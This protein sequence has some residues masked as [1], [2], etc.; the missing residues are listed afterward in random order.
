MQSEFALPYDNMS[1]LEKPEGALTILYN[2]LVSPK[3]AVQALSERRPYW[4]AFFVIVLSVLSRMTAGLLSPSSPLVFGAGSL[5]ALLCIAQFFITVIFAI[6]AASIYHFAAT[7]E[8]KLGDVRVLFL[9]IAVC[10]LPGIFFAPITLLVYGLPS[11]AATAVWTLCAIGLWVWSF[12][13]QII[14]V[15]NYYEISGGRSFFAVILPFILV[16]ALGAAVFVLMF[17]YL[18]GTIRGLVG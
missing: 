9:L 18:V 15:K 16:G 14:A 13:L 17:A 2:Q 8:F 6:A 3:K 7:N 12:V 10:F 4:L 5:F 11:A 1:P